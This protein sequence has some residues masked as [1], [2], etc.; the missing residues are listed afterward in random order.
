MLPEDHVH[1]LAVPA[2]EERPPG[3]PGVTAADP[4]DLPGGREQP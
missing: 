3:L 2:D 1:P 4:Q